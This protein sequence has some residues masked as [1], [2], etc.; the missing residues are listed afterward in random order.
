M[1]STWRKR[2]RLPENRARYQAS[3]FPTVAAA[4]RIFIDRLSPSRSSSAVSPALIWPRMIISEMGSSILSSRTRRI[5]RAPVLSSKPLSIRHPF[6]S[7]VTSSLSSLVARRSSTFASSRSKICVTSAW[8]RKPKGTSAS[9]RFRNSGLK[10]L[11]RA[12]A[13]KVWMLPSSSE[14]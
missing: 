13:T 11:S 8:V 9:T 1:R 5:P 10:W 4:F 7:A 3:Y 2:A 14:S 6:A 12:S